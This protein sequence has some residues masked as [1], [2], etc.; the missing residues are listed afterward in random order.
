MFL[1][2]L[3]LLLIGAAAGAESTGSVASGSAMSLTPPPAPPAGW[4]ARV[5]RQ[6]R[7]EQRLIIRI[8]PG[9]VAMPPPV[10]EFEEE[11]QALRQA[12]HKIGKCLAVA[13][14]ATLE[15][16]DSNE[17]LLFLR[18]D[19]VIGATLEKHCSARD[20][21]AGFYVE[22]HADGAICAGRDSLQSRSG[23]NCK[24]RRLHELVAGRDR[25]FP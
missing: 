19:R 10:E 23:A 21:Y 11:Q 3:A 17:L 2:P 14:I 8:V 20:F 4:R 6:V 22:R 1:A 7:I 16:G 5:W 13:S 12:E 24:V 15:A 25:R 9:P 18:D